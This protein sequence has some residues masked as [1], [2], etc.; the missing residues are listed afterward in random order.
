MPAD[1]LADLGRLGVQ[2]WADNGQLRYRAPAHTLTDDLRAEITR[3][4][5][6]LIALLQDR[7]GRR[8]PE[9]VSRPALKAD[10][11]RRHDPFP[12]TDIQQAY[13]V[14]RGTLF[15]LGNI[16]THAYF[17]FERADLD[18]E[19]LADGWRQLIARHEMLR[20][21]VR[22][23]G[24]QQILAD[25]PRYEVEVRDLRATPDRDAQAHVEAV[26]ARMAQVV[27]D[28]AC[29]PL[30]AIAVTR[31][32]AD[33]CRVHVSIDL[34]I[35]DVWSLFLL[36]REWGALY[37]D[38]AARLAPLALSFRDYVLAEA[39]RQSTP[40]YERAQAYWTARLPDLP[41]GPALPLACDPVAIAQ[42]RFVR[43]N[44]RLDAGTW[45]AIKRQAR[46][47]GVTPSM[48]LCTAFAEV[49]A[50]R[51]REPRFTLN[52]TLFQ[53]EPLHA[54]VT[55][56]VGD[57]TS[58]VLLAVDGRA[59][60]HFVARA[61]GVQRQLWHDLEHRAVS[62]VRVLRDL[63]VRG[64]QR[65][66][67]AM[68]V[69]FTSALG[70]EVADTALAT[71]WLGTLVN[72]VSQTPQVW[73]DHQVGEDGDALAFNWDAVEALFPD[74]LLD[75]MFADYLARLTRLGTD[76]AA[77]LEAP[78]KADTVASP[79]PAPTDPAPQATATAAASAS[80]A[81]TPSTVA[82]VRRMPIAPRTD[83]ERQLT[84][85][86]EDVLDVRPIGV[87]DS[88][89]DVGGN[90]FLAARMMI[91][92]QQVGRHLPMAALL[93][94]DTVERLARLLDEAQAT[95][96]APTLVRLATGGATPFFCV[97]P[98]GGHVM[99]YAE[100]AR[101]L[102]EARD[103]Y[104]LQARGLLGEAAPF[105]DLAA[106]AAHYLAE[107]RHVQPTGPYLLGGWSMGGTIAFE[108]AR[109]LAAQGQATQRLVLIDTETGAVARST[110]SAVSRQPGPAYDVPPGVDPAQL[111]HL[112][113][114]FTSNDR[115]LA[116][117]RERRYLGAV[118]LMRA[119]EQPAG[120]PHDLGWSEYVSGALHVRTVPGDH[121]TML[122]RPNVAIVGA[123]LRLMLEADDAERVS[124]S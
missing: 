79:D 98:I 51:S 69:V 121:Y 120:R 50:A 34:L 61:R 55:A 74:G 57:F 22:G 102:G 56:I 114:V 85:I 91:R 119:R 13:W 76:H 108:I 60:G 83:R 66:R 12:L 18:V 52:L 90:S 80:I 31:L 35:A 86:W 75:T 110:D 62:G 46:Q 67:L 93:Q 48:V 36:F 23:D 43:R 19:R 41:P 73:L 15:E 2:V 89:F 32:P 44:G 9:Q 8:T 33:R 88:F 26:R 1:F 105:T 113:Q 70:H 3:H 37:D 64:G 100:L 21:V 7:D 106:M 53:R 54:D 4:R 116:E 112:F 117:Y 107:I 82:A 72:G 11:K 94:A 99:C 14:G 49:L 97:H 109:Q 25:V 77:W 5:A 118:T 71:A 29:W 30:F 101:C 95:P 78:P 10:P 59:D 68:P 111:E 16:G 39:A 38:P 87:T 42:P 28:P 63:A 17:E 47:H 81:S 104:G 27:Y 45:Q 65:H 6:A 84:A 124:H 58:T 115:A 96:G 24:Q 122:Q 20:A 92:V 103:F 40:R 123:E